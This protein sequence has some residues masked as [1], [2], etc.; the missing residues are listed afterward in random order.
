MILFIFRQ[1]KEIVGMIG[2]RNNV[3]MIMIML[4]IIV[5]LMKLLMLMVV[6]I[7]RLQDKFEV[8]RNSKCPETG[9]FPRSHLMSFQFLMN[10]TIL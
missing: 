3:N 10:N 8:Q 1:T 4:D 9:P 2:Y 6:F 5:M 7:L